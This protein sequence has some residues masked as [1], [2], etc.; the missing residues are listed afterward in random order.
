[1]VSPGSAE[2][3]MHWAELER[4]HSEGM[5]FCSGQCALF[6][7]PQ[8]TQPTP[9]SPHMQLG[10]SSRYAHDLCR[11]SRWHGAKRKCV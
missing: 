4:W 10:G 6:W 9:T 11:S 3:K 8:K 2:L 1:M 5:V 7:D